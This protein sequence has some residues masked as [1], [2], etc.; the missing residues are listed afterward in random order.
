MLEIHIYSVPC[1]VKRNWMKAYPPEVSSYT[2]M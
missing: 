1:H 2:G